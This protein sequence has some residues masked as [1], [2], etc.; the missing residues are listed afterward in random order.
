[1]FYRFLLSRDIT[2]PKEKVHEIVDNVLIHI[3]ACIAELRRLFLV[4]N[5]I[6][7]IKYGVVLWILTYVGAWF[8]G[9][10]LVII[11]TCR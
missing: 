9:L 5:L 11:G 3:N 7:S 10:T 6:D 4:E 2:L 1:M 8:N